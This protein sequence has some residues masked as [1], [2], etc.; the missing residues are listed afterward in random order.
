MTEEETFYDIWSEGNYG[1]FCDTE[2]DLPSYH[3]PEP[4]TIKTDYSIYQQLD[5]IERKATRL[6]L[7]L[8]YVHAIYL[9]LTI[10]LV[11]K[12]YNK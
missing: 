9:S 5:F 6:E 1:H 8:C 12:I 10:F 4:K 7:Y 2:L 3:Q 11:Y